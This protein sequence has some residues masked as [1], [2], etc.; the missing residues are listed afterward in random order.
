MNKIQGLRLTDIPLL[1]RHLA[2]MMLKTGK[3]AGNS[4]VVISDMSYFILV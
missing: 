1:V 3:M 2:S 4:F